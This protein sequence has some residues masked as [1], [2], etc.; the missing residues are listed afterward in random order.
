MN[1]DKAQLLAKLG[2][3][4]IG[5]AMTKLAR[6]AAVGALEVTP[7]LEDQLQTACKDVRIIRKALMRALGFNE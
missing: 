2:A 5:P 3:S 1:K 4:G 6:S 7:E